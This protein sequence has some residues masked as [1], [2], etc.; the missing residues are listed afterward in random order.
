MPSKIK[1]GSSYRISRPAADCFENVRGHLWDILPFL[2][3]PPS[4]SV[5][6]EFLVWWFHQTKTQKFDNP[7]NW[8][9]WKPE[10]RNGRPSNGPT[11]RPPS[12]K[13]M[14]EAAGLVSPVQRRK[15]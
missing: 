11:A 7:P 5:A 4:A 3:K 15:L 13:A 9:Q 8:R 12:P 1:T 2:E 6:I 10:T 14:R